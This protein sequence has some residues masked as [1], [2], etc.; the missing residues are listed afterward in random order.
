MLKSE[1]YK[2][3]EQQHPAHYP[4]TT[5]GK[6]RPWFICVTASSSL[7]HVYSLVHTSSQVILIIFTLFHTGTISCSYTF[8]LLTG[9]KSLE[10]LCM[11]EIN[12]DNIIGPD[13]R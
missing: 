12:T 1:F 13:L 11:V 8:V 7:A 4:L 9:N 5:S 3:L 2:A 6:Q 10:P